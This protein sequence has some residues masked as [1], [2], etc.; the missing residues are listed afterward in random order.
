MDYSRDDID[1]LLNDQ[2]RDVAQAE[3]VYDA[4]NNDECDPSD[5]ETVSL[6]PNK[7]VPLGAK[8][9]D[10]F[11]LDN[12]SLSQAHAYLLGNCDET[13]PRDLFNMSDEVESDLP[14]G[15]ENEP[16]EHLM[17]PSIPKDNGEVLLTRTDVPET[18]IDVPSEEFVYLL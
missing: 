16:S 15:Y 18:T 14:Q 13:V 5:A 6:F 12:K 10:P 11:I 4:Q 2:F 3:E 1:G 8:K 9:T 7:G 17:G